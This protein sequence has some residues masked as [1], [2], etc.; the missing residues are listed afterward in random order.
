M[1][2]PYI[3]WD[4]APNAN[5]H[6]ETGNGPLVLAASDLGKMEVGVGLL[7]RPKL[8]TDHEVRYQQL[9]AFDSGVAPKHGVHVQGYQLMPMHMAFFVAN[10]LHGEPQPM[11]F[12]DPHGGESWRY[13]NLGW[14]LSLRGYVGTVL[15]GGLNNTL[16]VKWA[17]AVTRAP[18]DAVGAWTGAVMS[19]FNSV[20]QR[21][22]HVFDILHGKRPHDVNWQH[23]GGWLDRDPGGEVVNE[24]F[25]NWNGADSGEVRVV[26][27]GGP[28]NWN[29]LGQYW[30]GAAWADVLSTVC[31]N[32]KT[33]AGADAVQ[34]ALLGQLFAGATIPKMVAP[35]SWPTQE[36]FFSEVSTEQFEPWILDNASWGEREWEEHW[37]WCTGATLGYPIELRRPPA[38]LLH[39]P[40]G[41]DNGPV[42]LRMSDPDLGICME[43]DK[44]TILW[45]AGNE[46]RRLVTVYDTEP[47]AVTDDKFFGSGAPFACVMRIR[48]RE[49]AA[50]SADRNF[51]SFGNIFGAP[52]LLSNGIG[53]YWQEST[54]RLQCKYFNGAIWASVYTDFAPGDYEDTPVDI[55]FAWTGARGSTIGRNSYELRIIIDGRTKASV[56][57]TT[58]QLAGTETA[59]V[60][61]CGAT[62]GFKG[63]LR[64][65]AVFGD[66]V[67]DDE[68]AKA[69]NEVHDPFNNPSF[70]IAGTRPG[71][72]DGWDWESVQAKGGFA[73][74]CA[75]DDDLDPWHDCY[76]DFNGGWGYEGWLAA[77]GTTDV[78]LA[79]FIVMADDRSL[80]IFDMFGL[81]AG[82]IPSWLDAPTFVTVYEDGSGWQSWRDKVAGSTVMP[83]ELEDFNQA[84]NNEP[85]S[86]P[87]WKPGTAMQGVLQGAPLTFP[88]EITPDADKLV[89]FDAKNNEAAVL[90]VGTGSYADA[91]ALV[92]EL[93]ARLVAAMPA[94]NVEFSSW[95]LSSEEGLLLTW[96]GGAGVV[97][98]VM[99][100]AVDRDAREPLGLRN[101]GPHSWRNDLLYPVSLLAN[102]PSGLNADDVL[103]VDA[104]SLLEFEI[105]IDP[106][107]TEV[108]TVAYEMTLALF[109]PTIGLG[110]FTELF[111]LAGWTSSAVWILEYLDINLTFAMFDAGATQYEDFLAV[112]WPTMT[113]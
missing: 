8:F 82:N 72:A 4:P 109:D 28:P 27:A 93:N 52:L 19:A 50:W 35:I 110:T 106:S 113:W 67:T 78:S 86:E 58:L 20:G 92:A 1:A 26:L 68:I 41:T 57:A 31:N 15:Q 75:Y 63:L 66:A 39:R 89:V 38:D 71:E 100:G 56:I 112:E 59:T 40:L 21:T 90:T 102:V 61:K 47:T 3:L 11:D 14:R 98:K 17:D 23:H 76:E 73:E 53:L 70:E 42:Q 87:A 103:L 6:V 7:G 33:H 49:I 85:L 83:S 34:M 43:V 99:L 36:A 30:T 44:D 105:V 96:K 65:V 88:L 22:D 101:F 111:L 108:F 12:F 74:F 54:G 51:I 46:D 62:D 81:G 79:E 45:A 18:W 77:L 13:V 16:R 84:W 95:T 2:K 69:F 32:L 48:P 24:H 29:V 104:W 55:A 91:V 80:E 37:E 25:A 107:T 10:P 9:L 64:A 5:L 94:L 97:E 60:G